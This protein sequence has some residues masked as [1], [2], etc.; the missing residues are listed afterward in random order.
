MEGKPPGRLLFKFREFDR[1]GYGHKMLADNEL[2]FPSPLTFN[3]P[4]DCA[5]PILYYSGAAKPEVLEYFRDAAKNDLNFQPGPEATERA[6]RNFARRIPNDRAAAQKKDLKRTRHVA[7]KMGIQCFCPY[8]DNRLMWA[9]YSK[10]HTGFAIGYK[11]IPLYFAVLKEC[12]GAY[13]VC[14]EYQDN[15]PEIIPYRIKLSKDDS[16]WGR[17]FVVKHSHW[18]YEKEYRFI[19]P[20]GAKSKIIVPLNVFDRVIVGMRTPNQDIRRL[21]TILKDRGD[22]LPLYRAK[23]IF[24]SYDIEFEQLDY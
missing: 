12:R 18:E 16:E 13:G 21:V 24:L 6:F 15:Y 3:D 17:A 23:Q 8:E 22:N 10:N 7:S 14:V 9:H 2:Y 4:Y 11:A 20:D 19:W 1:N 5:I